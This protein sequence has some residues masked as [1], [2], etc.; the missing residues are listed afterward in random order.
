MRTMRRED[1]HEMFVPFGEAGYVIRYRVEADRVLVTR[2][3]HTRE[4]R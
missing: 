4:D 3:F 1:V 2:I